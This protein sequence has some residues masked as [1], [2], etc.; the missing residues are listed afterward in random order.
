M[1]KNSV[2]KILV[3]VVAVI[4]ISLI[5]FVGIYKQKHGV[6][7]NILPDYL[8]GKDVSGY[9]MVTLKVDESTTKE[10][11]DE[12]NSEEKATQENTSEDTNTTNTEE[13]TNTVEK[14]GKE[15]IKRSVSILAQGKAKKIKE[16]IKVLE[17]EEIGKEIIKTNVNIL[18][19][20][21]AKE[22]KEIIKVLEEEGIGKEI[23]KRQFNKIN[24]LYGNPIVKYKK[25]IEKDHGRGEIRE[26]FLIYN[27]DEIKDKE[28]IAIVGTYCCTFNF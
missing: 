23:I 1:K 7:E 14:I 25:T 13:N 27:T 20:G 4:L 16:I 28:K 24:N 21:K 18:V 15:V 12:T 19:Q 22:I 26:Y 3:I 8:L 17:E 10:E 5:S 11:T 6:M 9:R 2:L